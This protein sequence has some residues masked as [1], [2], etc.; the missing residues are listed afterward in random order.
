MTGLTGERS[1]TIVFLCNQAV[2]KTVVLNKYLKFLLFQ[3]HFLQWY[4]VNV[5]TLDLFLLCKNILTACALRGVPW[6][7][8]NFMLA[9]YRW[10]LKTWCMVRIMT[11]GILENRPNRF[12]ECRST[13]TI[14]IKFTFPPNNVS[15]LDDLKTIFFIF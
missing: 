8:H 4:F 6:I 12:I 1:L 11:I 13:C 15:L 14:H 9:R 5:P 2:I 7:W 10:I 3:L